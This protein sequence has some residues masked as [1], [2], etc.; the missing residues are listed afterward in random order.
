MEK[1]LA[2]VALLLLLIIPVSLKAQEVISRLEI[3]EKET[4]VVGPDNVL[5]VDTLVMHDKAVIQFNPGLPAFIGVNNAYV[6]KSCKLVTKGLDGSFRRVGIYGSNG[7]DGDPIEMDIHFEALGSLT[8]DTRGG[9]GDNGEDGTAERVSSTK[10]TDGDGTYQAI[11]S[12][13]PARAGGAGGNGGNGG[14]IT[15]TYSTEGFIPNFNRHR[16]MHTIILLYKGGKGGKPGRY[17][18]T[19]GKEGVDGKVKLNNKNLAAAQ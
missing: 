12:G 19:E 9:N 13:S 15:L 18:K 14:N 6:G 8:I 4:Y 3:K 11:S 2:Y 10:K 7:H 16:N 17:G 1:N 5:L